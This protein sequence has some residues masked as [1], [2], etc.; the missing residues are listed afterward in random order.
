MWNVQLQN[1]FTMLYVRLI[2]NGSQDDSSDTD[3]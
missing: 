1:F 2:K 3:S